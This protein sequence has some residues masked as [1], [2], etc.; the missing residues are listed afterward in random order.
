MTRQETVAA[1]TLRDV[2]NRDPHAV[3]KWREAEAEAL[4]KVLHDLRS[5]DLPAGAMAPVATS[6]PGRREG[7]EDNRRP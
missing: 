3:A 2:D 1:V 5:S 6:G 4:R 7:R